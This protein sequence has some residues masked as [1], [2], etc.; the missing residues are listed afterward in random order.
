VC[1][2]YS[3]L[4]YIETPIPTLVGNS[5]NRT[6]KEQRCVDVEP[7]I[8]GGTEAVPM[9]FPHMVIVKYTKDID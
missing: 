9:E 5:K 8:V 1:R 3:K 2:E 6:M 7:L 4:I